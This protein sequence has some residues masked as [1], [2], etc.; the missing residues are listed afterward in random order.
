[1]KNAFLPNI[2]EV[3]MGKPS[4]FSE[5]WGKNM[6]NFDDFIN[7][8][9]NMNFD[10][11]ISKTKNVAEELSRRGASA[12][13]LSKKR[14]ELL[15]CKSKL[16]RLYEDFG[17]LLYDAK[18]GVDVSEVDVDVKFNEITQMKEKI[19]QLASELEEAKRAN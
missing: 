13:E 8:T 3:S 18:N 19:A 15:D 12:L 10:E 4:G 17:H 5:T 6:S 2:M 14:I 1:M 16:S 9:K 11:V 7:K